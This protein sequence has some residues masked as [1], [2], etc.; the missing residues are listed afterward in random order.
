MLVGASNEFAWVRIAQWWVVG[1]TWKISRVS[2]S[3]AH[4]SSQCASL[5]QRATDPS[6]KMAPDSGKVHA[7][8]PRL[9]AGKGGAVAR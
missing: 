4:S 8:R 3:T 6:S 2:E 1:L 9:C 7:D 5:T